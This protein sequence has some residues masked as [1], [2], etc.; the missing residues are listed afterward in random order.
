MF[1]YQ[2]IYTR[3]GERIKQEA[4]AIDKETLF[5]KESIEEKIEYDIILY[6]DLIWKIICWEIKTN[7]QFNFNA[8]TIERKADVIW[9]A[10]L[11]LKDK[12]KLLTLEILEN[13][14]KNNNFINTEEFKEACI[15]LK[16][17]WFKFSLDDIPNFTSSV[18]NYKD[19]ELNQVKLDLT[20]TQKL[21]KFDWSEENEKFWKEF[22]EYIEKIWVNELILEWIETY[23]DFLTIEQQ[24]D[25]LFN[26]NIKIY[27]QGYYF[28]K[29]QNLIK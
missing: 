28:E 10:I 5:G 20:Q 16:E 22:K 11:K 3:G 12:I 29:P 13:W 24:L 2:W 7:T 1:N 14:F 23:N 18:S 19:I 4:L 9:K 26:H 17:L 21:I 6:N 8:E 25:N 15:W 27:Y